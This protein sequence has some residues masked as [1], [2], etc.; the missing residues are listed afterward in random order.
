[1][2]TNK[3]CGGESPQKKPERRDG[4]P[5]FFPVRKKIFPSQGGGAA[6]L[7]KIRDKTRTN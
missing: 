6:W 4:R 2:L 1:M 5:D 7:G 3:A